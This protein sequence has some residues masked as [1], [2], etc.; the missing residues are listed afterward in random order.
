MSAPLFP[1]F[2]DLQGRRVL[3]VG[4]GPVAERKTEALLHA[5]ARPRVGAPDL[6]PRLRT[7]H[8]QG[9]IDWIAG[10]FD[11][12]WLADAWLVV[13][14]TDDGHVN[15]AV[16]AAAEA[17][18]LF[19][20][21]VDDA[22]LSTFHVPAIVER[23]PL[24]VAI[25]SGGGA[26]MLARHLRRQLETLLDD[27]WASLA[28]L[29]TRQRQ[30]I[31]QRFPQPAE[32]RRFFEKLLAGPLP[33]LFRQQLHV[34]AE[35][36]FQAMLDEHAT[37]VRSGSVAV[38]G[39]GPGDAG[40]LTLNALRAMNE[41]DVVLH[42]RLVSEDVLRLGRR[43]AT[44]IEVGKSASGHSTRQDDIHAL[45]L[46]HARAGHRVVRL[47]GGDP[48]VFGRG[49]EELEF[50]RA[51]GI[52]Y[53]VVPGITAAVACAAYA[54]IPLTHRD[55]AQS[56]KLVTAH[57]KDSFDTLDWQALAQER[58]TLAVYMGVAGLEGLRDRLLQHGRAPSTPFALVENG[59]RRD[60]RVIGGT[61]ADLAETARFH[62]VRSPALLILGEV[63]AL[64]DTLH[65][66]GAPPVGAPTHSRNLPVPTLQ[67]A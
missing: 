10:R 8:E 54:G 24:Q 59:S 2:A 27:S 11:V 52:P 32:R 43:D 31:R 60:Q 44:Y 35:Q 7:W 34:Q 28:H 48:F 55:H 15:Q 6:T 9:R 58:Q 20:N 47:K 36:H 56:L 53:E 1:L 4:G 39:A 19:A 49:G 61:L 17:R 62:Q 64:A 66:F 46:E 26:P 3:V 57:C 23:G 13:A 41:A 45:M 29:F 5:G 42:D 33:R 63:A 21:V 12:A 40:L 51:H 38:V 18:Q 16:A 22:E 65:W 30:R 67:A 14:A 25:S 50:L 37:V